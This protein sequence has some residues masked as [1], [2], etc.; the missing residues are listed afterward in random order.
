VN[1][2][3]EIL[4]YFCYIVSADKAPYNSTH[5]LTAVAGENLTM[6]CPGS[7]GA[8]SWL[9][10]KFE[11]AQQKKVSGLSIPRARVNDSGWYV[12]IRKVLPESWT[13]LEKYLFT[14]TISS[15]YIFYV[16]IWYFHN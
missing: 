10:I 6:P 16:F 8:I 1:F 14:V 11:T 13:S 9:Y 3:A 5:E 2:N 12:C 15:K 4:L 7:L